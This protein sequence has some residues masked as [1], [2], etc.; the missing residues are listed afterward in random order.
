[1]EIDRKTRYFTKQLL[2]EANKA[3]IREN[4]NYNLNKE[5]L[6]GLSDDYI[7]PVWG[8]VKSTKTEIRLMII[9]NENGKYALLD[10]SP[11]RFVSLPCVTTY[12]DGTI[13]IEPI[14][15]TKRPYRNERDWK[16]VTTCQPVRKQDQFRRKVLIAYSFQCAACNIKVKAIL[17]AAH[18]VPV[19]LGGDDSIN[20]GICLCASHEI[21]FDRGILT[22]MTDGKIE[23]QEGNDLN[24]DFSYIRFPVNSD[25][26]PL[27]ENFRRKIDL[28]NAKSKNLR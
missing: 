7:Y 23:I 9:I 26:F 2:I 10:I 18:I 11:I 27:P 14:D 20:N 6:D 19:S 25:D 4:R 21:A 8:I 13:N 3:S 12:I 1:M 24:I 17:R 16:N 5:F 22:I 15:T 28:M